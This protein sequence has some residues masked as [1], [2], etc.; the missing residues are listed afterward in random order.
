MKTRR[1]IL[2]LPALLIALMLITSTQ[3][4]KKTDDPADP[5]PPAKGLILKGRVIDA[6]TLTGIPGATVYLSHSTVLTTNAGGEYQLDCTH[7]DPAEFEVRV[8]AAG[9]GYGY[10][11]AKIEKNAATAGTIV[12]K[13]LSAAVMAGPSGATLLTDD[14]EAIIPDSRT[15]LTVPAGAFATP[16]ALSLTRFTGA[17]V[18]GYAPVGFLN[19]CAVHI[20]PEGVTPAVPMELRFTLP[21]DFPNLNTLTLMRYSH[22]TDT[23]LP[24]YTQVP[25]GHATNTAVALLTETGTYC[26][27][28]PGSFAE[29]AGTGSTPVLTDLSKSESLAEFSFTGKN[30]YTPGVPSDVSTLFLKNT[31]SQNTRL[32][33]LRTRFDASNQVLFNY[34]GSKPDSLAGGKSTSAGFYRWTPRASKTHRLMPVTITLSGI[35]VTGTIEKEFYTDACGWMY[36][37]DQGGGG[38]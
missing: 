22:G 15:V 31:A 38:K 27:A 1:R 11:P 5:R 9:Y 36:V 33:G 26:L 17:E 14:P 12:L 28:V 4:C 20:G 6:Q 7:M 2:L 16:T 19:V 37:H 29:T 10:A 34:I 24:A 25:V 8:M 35:P 32:Y 18:P 3:S 13:K 21:F 23:W 30:E